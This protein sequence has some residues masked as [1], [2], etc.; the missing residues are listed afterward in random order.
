[1]MEYD[2]VLIHPP[3]T[4]DFREQTMFSGP[5]AYTVGESTEQFMI[6]SVGVLSIA[7]Y[8]DRH[9]YRVTVD[10]ICERM[11]KDSGFDVEQHIE[12]ISAKVFAIGLHW[13]V[14][15]QGA[16]EI[17]YLC[18]RLH[19]EAMV[20]MG[21]LTSTVFAEEIVSKCKYVD[22]V[23][24]G[25]AEKPFLALMKVLKDDGKL[26]GVPNLTYRNG[27]GEVI[28]NP[29]MPP[30][31]D[32]DEYEFTRLDLLEPKEVIFR[33][34]MPAH[35]MIP[36]CRGCVHNCT[37]CGGSAYSYK[38]YLGR[39]KPAFRSPRK[40]ADDINRLGEQGV[41]LIFLFQ[42]PRMGGRGYWRQLFTTL[43]EE[44]TQKVKLSME[45]FGP[46]NEEYIK[47]IS[48]IG[49]PVTLTVSPESGVDSV[50]KAHGRNYT[51]E[52]IL[53]TAK[54][55]KK[56]NV[57]LGI[58]M[59]IALGNDTRE[60]IEQTWETWEEICRLN[61]KTGGESQILHAFGPMI[62][63]DPGSPAFDAPGNH[64][65]KLI[66]K[67]FEDYF[68]GL[69]QPAWHQWISYETKYLDRKKIADLIM[70]SIEYSIKLRLKYGFFSK[71]EADEAL[72]G[73]V[74]VSKM[75]MEASG[76]VQGG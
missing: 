69:Y 39:C 74:T 5:I 20:V 10:N 17:A 24:R 31:E 57:L 22:G 8:L 42:D 9:G 6:P 21:G 59:M 73:Q 7:E 53:K 15:S 25:E 64:G 36:I 45:I 76:R 43:R 68:K 75:V 61:R 67:N 52:D 65:F 48:E 28:N 19:P 35:W 51:M 40:I 63:L 55:C 71:E 62:L 58:H 41:E 60:T 1:M 12:N 29:L 32:L 3:A 23:I 44:I 16:V 11:V 50:R 47:A 54:L 66:F 14:H 38:K 34:D 13:C 37:T 27:E 33:K 26:E 70:D 2:A 4:Y 18:K 46:A 49:V 30:N 72:Y 56:Y